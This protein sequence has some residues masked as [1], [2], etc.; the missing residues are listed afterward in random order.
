MAIDIDIYKKKS[1]TRINLEFLDACKYGN[2]E[3]VSFLL[4]SPHLL[5]QANIHTQ[6]DLAFIWCCKY[7]QLDVLKYLLYSNDLKENLHIKYDNKNN[8]VDTSDYELH[9]YQA[10]KAACNKNSIKILNYLI[11]EEYVTYPQSIQ[12]YLTYRGFDHISYLFEK[13]ALKENLDNSLS[14]TSYQRSIKI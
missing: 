13:R 4:T 11:F 10:F 12:T 2:I 7:D 6:K 5:C 9:L 1:Q 3:L 8:E 14:T